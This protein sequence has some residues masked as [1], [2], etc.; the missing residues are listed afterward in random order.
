VAYSVSRKQ[1]LGR[2]CYYTCLSPYLQLTHLWK[3][4]SSWECARGGSFLLMEE[5]LEK[6]HAWELL[7]CYSLP[8][9]GSMLSSLRKSSSLSDSLEFLFEAG[10]QLCNTDWP[11]TLCVA[12]A[13]LQFITLLPW[14]PNCWDYRS[15]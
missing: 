8:L 12:Q 6:V 10:S 3:S 1:R 4:R 7:P 5:T 9:I 15:T 14:P 13:D 11:G 2:V